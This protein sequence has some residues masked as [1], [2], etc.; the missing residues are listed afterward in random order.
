MAN[1]K[2]D[3]GGGQTFVI[4]QSASDLIEG[5][6]RGDLSRISAYGGSDSGV[7]TGSRSATL[8]R[9]GTRFGSK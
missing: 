3:I 6:R 7:H 8:G 1:V 9:H 2:I 5:I 4:T